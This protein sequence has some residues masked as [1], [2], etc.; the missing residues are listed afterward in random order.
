[1]LHQSWK[2]IRCQVL[3]STERQPC[4]TLVAQ[5]RYPPPR[6]E[7]R[8]VR[9]V[10]EALEKTYGKPR[11]GN[12]R[13]PVDDLIYIILSNKTSP[14]IARQ[15]F[16]RL[17]QRFSTWDDALTSSPS[18]VRKILRP[19]GLA[20][21]KSRQI[22]AALKKLRIDFGSCNLDVLRGIPESQAQQYLIAL[23]GVSEKVAKCVMIYTLG[24]RVLPVDSHVHRVSGRLGWT[25]RKRADQCHEELEAIVPPE[26]RYAFH[27]D[28][29][30][31]GRKTCRPTSPL[32]GKCPIRRY[33]AYFKRTEC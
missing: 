13:E 18:V 33:C 7:P 12:P 30:V 21:V 4:R 6:I 16:V 20:T 3:S 1:M 27:V 19:A 22:R 15:T 28:C 14:Q 32:C 11:L 26:K 23:P 8:V 5:K 2:T 9:R 25:K 24:F 17:K 31:H 29:I 10:C